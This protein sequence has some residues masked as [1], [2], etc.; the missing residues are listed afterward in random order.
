MV[1][2]VYH[3]DPRLKQG[4][5]HRM[6][7]SKKKELDDFRRLLIERTISSDVGTRT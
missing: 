3:V 4:Q 7:E 6:I 5:F 1:V 2:W